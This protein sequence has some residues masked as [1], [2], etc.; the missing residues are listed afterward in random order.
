MCGTHAP[1]ITETDKRRSF[2][3]MLALRGIADEFGCKI[4]EDACH[5]PGASYLDRNQRYRVGACAHSDAA[6]F[7]FHAIKHIAMGEGGALCSA[8]ESV[9]EAALLLRSHG[10]CRD[11][12][13]WTNAPEPDAPW[14]YEMSK[15][16]WNYRLTEL[17][18]ALGRSQLERLNERINRRRAIAE[19]YVERLQEVPN[20]KLPTLPEYSE[21]H[22]WHLFQVAIDFCAVGRSRGE[23]MRDLAA[24]GIGTQVL[25]IP[26]YHQP[27]YAPMV[28]EPLPGTE[29]FY[30][31]TL[32]V[33]MY[34]ELEDEEVDWIA[35]KIEAIVSNRGTPPA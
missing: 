24:Q 16:G 14:Y 7:S 30:D 26:L 33:P 32:A 27:Y 22:V 11:A 12:N 8:D 23:V 34:P 20:L 35:S 28:N 15:I 2:A 19:R 5:A 4:V 18:A 13:A 21:S 17:Q 25:Y 6:A 10:M 1:R 29:A 9:N 31:C 3:D